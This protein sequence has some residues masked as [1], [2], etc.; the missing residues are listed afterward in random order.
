[1]VVS[2]ALGLMDVL[3]ERKLKGRR[4]KNGEVCWGARHEKEIRRMRRERERKRVRERKR[5][6][7]VTGGADIYTAREIWGEETES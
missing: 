7:R 4:L 5:K 2:R 1:M 6:R 3:H